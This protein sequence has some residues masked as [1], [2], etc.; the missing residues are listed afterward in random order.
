MFAID[1][2]ALARWQFGVTTV[3]HL[4]IVSLSIGLAFLVA[5]MQTLQQN[6][7]SCCM[8]SGLR[9]YLR[10]HRKD[11]GADND[12]AQRLIPAWLGHPSRLPSAPLATGI[13]A[14]AECLYGG[15]EG[16]DRIC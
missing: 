5:V 15:L 6:T 10:D 13:R 12:Y 3:Y 9:P 4:L 14:G 16:E 8:S 7:S 1:A 11:A 2:P